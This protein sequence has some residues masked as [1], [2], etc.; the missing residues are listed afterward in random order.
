MK[1]LIVALLLAI[2]YAQTE[3]SYVGCFKDDGDRDLNVFVGNGH[4]SETCSRAC[5]DYLY[6]ALQHHGECRCDNHFSSEAKYEK[7]DDSQCGSDKKGRGWTNAVF[8]HTRLTGYTLVGNGWCKSSSGSRL[9]TNFDDSMNEHVSA[10]GR[11]YSCEERCDANSNCIGYMTEDKAKCQLLFDTDNNAADGIH[12]ADSETRNYCWKK[13]VATTDIGLCTQQSLSTNSVT[14]QICEDSPQACEVYIKKGTLNGVQVQSGHDY[15]NAIGLSCISMF[16]DRNDC[17][18]KHQYDSCSSTGGS[19]SD[20]IVR[21]GVK[22]IVVALGDSIADWSHDKLSVYCSGKDVSNNAV[23]G[24]T[25]EEWALD[26]TNKSPTHIL[27]SIDT[28]YRV[29]HVWI[30]LGVNDYWEDCQVPTNLASNLQSIFNKVRSLKP[31]AKIIVTGYAQLSGDTHYCP[32]DLEIISKVNAALKTICESNGV[33]FVD[34][35]WLFGG[36]IST[37]ADSEY[38]YD[39]IHYN[40]KGYCRWF[41]DDA[42]Q[43][44]LECGT[45]TEECSD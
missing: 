1:I 6:F 27:N 25:A 20:H 9:G 23:G 32:D 8:A 33:T 45:S 12:G 28:K 14:R 19:T 44:A 2:G 10:G 41:T 22:D 13:N 3:F 26:S 4:N 43:S 11:A 38:Y 17:R 34:N 16:E 5:E 37:H 30:S 24:S 42:M 36:S 21:C 15:C 40:D 31:N 29:T 35:T 7:V 39:W 18:R